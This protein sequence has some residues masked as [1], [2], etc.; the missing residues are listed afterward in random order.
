MASVIT[1]TWKGEILDKAYNSLATASVPSVFKV[2]RDQTTALET[3]TDLDFPIPISGTEQVDDCDAITGWTDSADLTTTLNTTTFI[4]GTGSLNLT[5]DGTGSTTAS[6][7]K[8]VTSL[9]FTSK[10]LSLFLK[11]ST[12]ALALLAT[13]DAVTIRYGSNSSNYY[14]WTRDASELTADVF[15]AIDLLDTSNPDSI[16]GTPTD[17]SMDFFHIALE[18]ALSASTWSAG[19]V[20]MDDIK[21]ASSDDFTKDF[22]SGY[23]IIDKSTLQVTLRG[24]LATT[25]GNGFIID[26]FGIFNTDG[27]PIMEG[28]DDF[29]AESKT[30]TDELI[31]VAK[32]RLT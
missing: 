32:N 6:T 11:V 15:T 13:T 8:T 7:E 16:T 4:Q 10:K 25:E 9:D 26:G 28:I 23:P 5:K 31:F 12:S 22:S 29:T 21:L 18:T 24:T 3:D 20:I 19:D 17:A 1:K 30:L 14:Q 27:S 2:G